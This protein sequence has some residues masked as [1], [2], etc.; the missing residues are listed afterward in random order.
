MKEALLYKKL[1]S[2]KVQCQNCP[3]FCIISP[4]KR[5]ICGV[6]ENIDE[7]LY[8]SSSKLSREILKEL[9]VDKKLTME[10]TATMLGVGAS[11]VFKWLHKHDLPIRK[12]K[13]KKY[14]FS[15]D[16]KEKAYIL[17][18]VAGD[19]CA[20]RHS[21]QIVAELTTTHPAMMD[22]FH[23]VFHKYGTPTKR[24]KY[25]K[26]TERYE[27]VGYVILNNSFDFMLSKNFEINNEYFYH[28]L[29]G[30][31]DSEGCVHVYNNHDYLGLTILIY[32]SN[33]KL[34]EIIKERLE[35][36]GFH[37][38]FYKFFEKGE[39]TTNNYIRGSDLWVIAMHTIEEIL[40]L[41]EKMPIK[42]QEKID[43][44]KIVSASNTNKWSPIA[45]HIY[46][47]K[48]KIKNEVKEFIT[49]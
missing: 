7:K 32:N 29:A 19:I 42:H 5:G 48:A 1:K 28:F 6:R 37:P 21:R 9:Y 11:T 47:L 22:L 3:H 16:Q 44:I 25:N 31:F 12:F 14:N 20:Y 17:G 23:S 30:F 49:P 39:K 43:K 33:R 26:I 45:D 10:K 18:L 41:M 34:L 2:K 35:R 27:R 38:K 13:Y 40:V 46:D 15:G 4:R 8:N 24:L 36:D